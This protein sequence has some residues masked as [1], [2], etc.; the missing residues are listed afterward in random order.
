MEMN[1]SSVCGLHQLVSSSKQTWYFQITL[2][3]SF[4]LI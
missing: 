4:V 1:E 3:L 2:A